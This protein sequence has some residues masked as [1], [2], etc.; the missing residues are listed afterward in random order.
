MCPS[1]LH[2][3][4]LHATVISSWTLH[5]LLAGLPSSTVVPLW[6]IFHP[7]TR[8]WWFKTCLK[9][10]QHFFHQEVESSSPSLEYGL[11]HILLRIECPWLPRLGH[12]RWLASSWLFFLGWL[13]LE[14]IHHSLRAQVMWRECKCSVRQPTLTTR[15]LSEKSLRWPEPQSLFKGSDLKHKRP[16]TT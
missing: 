7:G 14:P 13:L 10:L 6:L 11:C 4:H 3:F 15:Y 1:T 8:M 16:R 5:W 12:K 2:I 9:I